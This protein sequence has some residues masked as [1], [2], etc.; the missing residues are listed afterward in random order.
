MSCASDCAGT[1]VKLHEFCNVPL[2][3]NDWSA[4]FCDCLCLM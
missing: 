1:E 3:E 2:E 4:S